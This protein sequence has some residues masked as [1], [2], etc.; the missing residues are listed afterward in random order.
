MMIIF[1]IFFIDEHRFLTKKQDHLKK[2]LLIYGLTPKLIERFH[3][4][5]FTFNRTLLKREI[6]ECVLFTQQTIKKNIW[7]DELILIL[8]ILRH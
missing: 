3:Y 8:R 2:P 4:L 5:Y 7:S 6:C 1:H